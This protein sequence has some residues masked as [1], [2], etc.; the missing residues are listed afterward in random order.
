MGVYPRRLAHVGMTVPDVDEADR[1]SECGAGVGIKRKDASVIPSPEV[2][3]WL[4]DVADDTDIDHQREVAR[5]IG[6]DTGA[7]QN[8]G[9]AVRSGAL[10]VPVRYHHSPVETAHQADLTATVDLLA[11]ALSRTDALLA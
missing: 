11:A 4:T 8:A 10:S 2:V 6:T 7:L 9:G 1:I 3:E 5:N